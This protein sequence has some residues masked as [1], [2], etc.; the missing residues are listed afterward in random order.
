MNEPN[1]VSFEM[2]PEDESAIM[3][4]L[5]V[6]KDK[7]FPILISLTPE[8]RRELPKM[9]DKSVSFVTKCFEYS[10]KNPELVPLYVDKTEFEKDVNGVT[11]LRSFY[12]PLEQIC[13]ALSDTVMAAGSEA[14]VSALSIYN[15]VKDAA[16]NNVPGAQT[17]YE[18][19]K[20]RFPGGSKK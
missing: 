11:K 16:R 13:N 9:G 7:L 1:L 10:G 2:S 4:A 20:Q 17:I 12:Q 15:L 6:L 5:Q 8:D 3:A 14:Y 19:L 18:D